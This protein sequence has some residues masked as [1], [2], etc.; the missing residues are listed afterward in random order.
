VSEL[1]EIRGELV[2]VPR[3][4]RKEV[5]EQHR[6][7]LDTR[8]VWLWNQRFG[9]V[10]MVYNQSPDLLDKT[11]ATLI[12]Q[13]IMARD[14]VSIKQVFQRLEGGTQ[15]DEDLLEDDSPMRI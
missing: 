2:P 1:D 13:A 15:Y 5:P 3:R 12:L 11:A 14:L 10:Q 8:V 7:S 4:W 9:T 6:M